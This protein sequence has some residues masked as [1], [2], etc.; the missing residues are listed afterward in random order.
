MLAG[1]SSRYQAGLFC[2]TAADSSDGYAAAMSPHRPES[3]LQSPTTVKRSA[4]ISTRSRE[5]AERSTWG[6]SD[7]PHASNSHPHG[8]SLRNGSGEKAENTICEVVGGCVRALTKQGHR[9]E[10]VAIVVCDTSWV[11]SSPSET[12]TQTYSELISVIQCRVKHAGGPIR[13]WLIPCALRTKPATH[14]L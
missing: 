4:E 2:P 1:R 6:S 13:G 11:P 9:G 10:P 7:T 14:V 8:N 12:L 3:Q 5:F